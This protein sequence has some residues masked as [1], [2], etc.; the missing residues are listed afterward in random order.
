MVYYRECKWCGVISGNE[1]IDAKFLDLISA[2]EQK[3]QNTIKK[4]KYMIIVNKR[5]K[6]NEGVN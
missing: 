6:K 5:L 2:Y 1:R 3:Q 4:P